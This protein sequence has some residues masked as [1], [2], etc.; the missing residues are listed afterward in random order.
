V[1]YEAPASPASVPDGPYQADPPDGS[2]E[3]PWTGRDVLKGLAIPVAFL[4]FSLAT[5]LIAGE[6]SDDYDATTLT[7]SYVVAIAVELFLFG[8]ALWFTRRKYGASFASLGL[9]WPDRGSWWLP[10]LLFFAAYG[11]LLIYVVSL[12]GLGVDLE[13]DVPSESYDSIGPV[14]ALAGLSLITA[15]FVEEVFFRGFTF[16]GLKR[17][18]GVGVSVLISGLIFGAFHLANPDGFLVF[19]PISLIGMIFAWGFFY[20]GSLMAPMIAHFAFNL[21]SFVAGF[22]AE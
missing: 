8:I 3:I 14:L 7:V 11:V 4:V 22:Y 10:V 21:V 20:S 17:P 1:E 15:P 13:A 6:Q 5:A 9:R 2:P 12:D 18:L 16:G 19:V